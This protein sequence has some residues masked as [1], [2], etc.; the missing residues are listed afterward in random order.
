M[1]DSDKQ[2]I[3][4]AGPW[5]YFELGASH[6]LSGYDHLLFLFGVIFFLT[7]FRDIVKFITAFT[8]GHSIT[9]VLATLFNIQAN[10]FL[11]DSVIGLTVLYK[12]FDNLN[13]FRKY[14]NTES[15]NLLRIVFVFGLIHGFGLSTRLQL[16]PL[17]NDGLILKILAFNI[18]VEMGQVLA[19]GFMLLLLAGWRKTKS[20]QEFSKVTNFGLICAGS[21]LFL[22]QLH[23]F[24]H[25]VYSDDFPLNQ[26][27]HYHVHSEMKTSNSESSPLQNYQKKILIDKNPHADGKSSTH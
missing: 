21:L 23:G 12:G 8:V 22:M 25:T 1:S 27:D 9:L 13:G 26:D 15:P 18:G 24:I 3:L 5:E 4:D 17:P 11:I 14:F 20:F 16:L 10:Y 2:K 19:L 7:N 6:M